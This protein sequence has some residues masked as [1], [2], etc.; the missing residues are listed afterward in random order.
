MRYLVLL[1]VLLSFAVATSA[2]ADTE[3]NPAPGASLFGVDTSKAVTF[4]LDGRT[5]IVNDAKSNAYRSEFQGKKLDFVCGRRSAK[6][7]ISLSSFKTWNEHSHQVT[8]Y[9]GSDISA[10]A[11]FCSVQTRETGGVIAIAHFA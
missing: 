9:F 6:N 10:V 7:V 2:L 11:N 1:V 4:H 3:N 8:V 5:L